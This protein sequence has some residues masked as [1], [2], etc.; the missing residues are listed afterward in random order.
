MINSTAMNPP[1]IMITSTNIMGTIQ[2]R[3]LLNTHTHTKALYD[4]ETDTSYT[5]VF[6]SSWMSVH[7]T[8]EMWS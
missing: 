7:F 2:T 1:T 3:A 4:F 8:E 6:M 5:D